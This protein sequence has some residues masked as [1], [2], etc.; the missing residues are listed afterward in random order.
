MSDGQRTPTK[1]EINTFKVLSNLDFTDLRKPEPTKWSPESESVQ[2]EKAEEPVIVNQRISTPIASLPITPESSLPPSPVP[3]PLTPMKVVEEESPELKE[4]KKMS[5]VDITLEKEALL[6]ELEIMEKQGSIKLHRQLTISDD[7]DTIQYQ[8]DRANM[9]ISTQQTV[10]WAKTGIRMGSGLIETFA[11][12]FGVTMVDGFSNNLC[13]DMNKFNKPLTKMY[14]KYWR[15]GSS[16]PETELAMIV[17]GAL[18]MTVLANRGLKSDSKPEVKP[19]QKVVE[20]PQFADVF[21]KEPEQPKQFKVPDWA[22]T[23]LSKPV[24]VPV[25]FAQAPVQK[26]DAF[27][28]TVPQRSPVVPV[29]VADSGETIKVE[30]VKKLTLTS[31]RSSRRKKEVTEE[32]NLDDD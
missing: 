6:Y 4:A 15:R 24:E 1:S 31:P 17:F 22:K 8:Y 7:L 9:I 5:E 16:S 14:R 28:E 2:E 12:K 11:K 25:H 27:V 32:L 3:R 21:Q 23:A 18:A 10:E 29:T 19:E 30:Q 13:K 20:K 26:V